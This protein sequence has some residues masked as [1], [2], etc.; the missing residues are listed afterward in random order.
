MQGR[1]FTVVS[2]DIPERTIGRPETENPDLMLSDLFGAGYFEGMTSRSCYLGISTPR[3]FEYFCPLNEVH[4]M[5][6]GFL[7][8]A[9]LDLKSELCDENGGVIMLDWYP[10][11]TVPEN[12]KAFSDV[13]N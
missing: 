11:D 8:R 7:Y 1:L 9:S 4:K 13:Q 5:R 6:V 12:V 3:G 10:K 2:H